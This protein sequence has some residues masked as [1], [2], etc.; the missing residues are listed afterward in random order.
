MHLVQEGGTVT[1]GNETLSN[2]ISNLGTYFIA[3]NVKLKL[4]V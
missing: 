1:S 3:V 4:S 2:D